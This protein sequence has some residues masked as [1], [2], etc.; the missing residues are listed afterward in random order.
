MPYMLLQSIFSGP[1]FDPD[2]CSLEQGDC[3]DCSEARDSDIVVSSGRGREA[4]KPHFFLMMV[5][6][7]RIQ[8]IGFIIVIQILGVEV[9][10]LIG[11]HV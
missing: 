6:L 8:R 7:F 4:L 5:S 2:A 3:Y 1:C 10:N 9:L 11:L